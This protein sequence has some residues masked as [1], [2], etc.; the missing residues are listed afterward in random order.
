[1]PTTKIAISLDKELFAQ[2]ESVAAE[3]N[4]PRSRLFALAL[5]EFVER[6]GNRKPLAD[7]DPSHGYEPSEAEQR[8]LVA[9][10]I[11]AKSKA[12]GDPPARGVLGRPWRSL[13]LRSRLPARPH[14]AIQND[15][16]SRSRIRTTVVC[17]LTSN[18]DR[19]SSPGNVLL[20]RG[21]ANLPKRSVVNVTQVFTVDR[22][23][24]VEKIGALSVSRVREIP[25]GLH[26]LLEPRDVE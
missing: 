21:E 4:T 25:Q 12:L 18:L 10:A 17:A 23:D 1:M 15:L 14:V 8:E 16:F 3:L 11:V 13:W 20:A 19:A 5:A 9:A 7:L 26:L 6:H 22:V 2:A 24:L